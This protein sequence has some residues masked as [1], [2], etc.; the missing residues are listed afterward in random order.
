[1]S[2]NNF[3]SQKKI[4][5]KMTCRQK[6][7]V[8]PKIVGQNRASKSIVHAK[9]H[10]HRKE[11]IFIRRIRMSIKKTVNETKMRSNHPI[12]RVKVSTKKNVS[13][14]FPFNKHSNDCYFVL[15]KLKDQDESEEKCSI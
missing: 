1:M 10:H 13:L 8:I 3:Y 9:H 7:S 15:N 2:G 6:K 5:P 14:Y 11:L 4:E 12:I